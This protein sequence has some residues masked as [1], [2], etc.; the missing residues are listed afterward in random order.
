MRVLICGDRDWSDRDK[1]KARLERLLDEVEEF[2]T[3]VEGEARGADTIAREEA[4]KLG[5]KV[6]QFP[7]QWAAFGR[8]AGPLRNQAM[9][10]SGIDLVI[11]FH[12]DLSR[13]RGTRD[14]VNRAQRARIEV[15]VID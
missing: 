6:Q 11:A 2:I 9:L 3:V 1:I 8:A 13:S 7:A 5:I 14:M 15:E 4:E 12:E 10:E